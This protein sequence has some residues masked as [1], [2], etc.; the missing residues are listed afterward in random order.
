MPPEEFLPNVGQLG[1]A[2]LSEVEFRRNPEF[3]ARRHSVEFSV[4][5][6]RMSVELESDTTKAGLEVGLEWWPAAED[7][8]APPYPFDLRVVVAGLFFWR[9]DVDESYREGWTDFNAPYL[10]M[11]YARSYVSI[12][13]GFSDLPSFTLPTFAVP[14]VGVEPDAGEF[15]PISFETHEGRDAE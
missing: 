14:R 7:E 12:I 2:W 5:L 10:L 15:G 8:E 3:D 11:P 13:T 6:R 4:E 1:R 9:E